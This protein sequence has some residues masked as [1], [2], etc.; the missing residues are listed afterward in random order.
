M[1]EP[2]RYSIQVSGFAIS[3]SEDGEQSARA[4]DELDSEKFVHIHVGTLLPDSVTVLQARY[5]KLSGAGTGDPGNDISLPPAQRG[6]LGSFDFILTH[7]TLEPEATYLIRVA[8]D[9][10]SK[11][12]KCVAT[13]S[14]KTLKSTK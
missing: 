11:D 4:W 13:H 6:P 7:Y 9:F 10:A 14:F 5:R 2:I 3:D 1:A 8:D 12:I